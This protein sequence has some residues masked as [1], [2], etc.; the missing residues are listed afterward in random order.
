MVLDEYTESYG[1]TRITDDRVSADENWTFWDGLDASGIADKIK[2]AETEVKFY[3]T[4]QTVMNA[5][6]GTVTELD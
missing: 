2:D 6:D 4:L 5:V 1:Q 3:D